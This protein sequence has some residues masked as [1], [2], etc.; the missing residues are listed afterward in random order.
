M[1]LGNISKDFAVDYMNKTGL[2]GYVYDF[3]VDFNTIDISDIIDI[4]KHLIKKNIIQNNIS[5]DYKSIHFII[6]F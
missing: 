4:D 6:K 2:S 1:C 5:F 3:S